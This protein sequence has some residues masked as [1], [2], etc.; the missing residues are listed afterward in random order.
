[1]P[2]VASPPYP[3]SLTVGY[4]NKAKGLIARISK[5]K[6]GITEELQKADKAFKNAPFKEVDVDA[7]I[8]DV[9]AKS[10]GQQ[11]KALEQFQD[12][13]LRKYQPIF[14]G[15]Q[16]VYSDLAMTLTQKVAEFEKDEKLQKFA[17]AVKVMA[18]AADKFTYAVS[19]GTVSD[20]N[21]KE[22]TLKIAYAGESDKVYGNA[23]QKIKD[24]IA[25]ATSDLNGYKT[26]PP[27]ASKYHSPFWN[28]VLR[29]IGVYINTA[30]KVTPGVK[31]KFAAPMKAA[32]ERWIE[33]KMPKKDEEVPDLI[34]QDIL[35]V[36]KFKA[37]SDN[38]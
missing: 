22:L 34:K 30:E 17:P 38:L 9:L 24:I 18:D 2:A 21:T 16:T 14:R 7:Q 35:L 20:S 23:L 12:E 5:V 27:T 31:A 1:M 3:Q 28:Q 29:N 4:W 26:K 15:L 32:G 6:T 33:S 19:W 10:K 8:K 37:I 25:T 13:Y 36:A 11:K